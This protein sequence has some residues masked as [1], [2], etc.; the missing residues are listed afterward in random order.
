MGS[1]IGES[2]GVRNTFVH[3]LTSVHLPG[4]SF[5]E[6]RGGFLTFLLFSFGWPKFSVKTQKY[7]TFVRYFCCVSLL[8]THF[9]PSGGAQTHEPRGP[10]PRVLS[11]ELHPDIQF[12]CM[13]PCEER[14]SKFF[15]SV[16]GAVVT[17][18]FAG[19]FQPGNFRRKLLS[20]G[21]PEVHFWGNGWV[22]YPPKSRVFPTELHPSVDF[23]SNV[24][25]QV[26]S[27]L[28]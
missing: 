12:F 26:Q 16:G 1:F 7:R 18:N 28:A 21:L 15:V 2:L 17:P 27:R 20:Q 14:K 10:K 6:N 3:E 25:V 4:T 9:G 13:I 22:V 11:T 5:W 8:S 19:V 24:D 23:S